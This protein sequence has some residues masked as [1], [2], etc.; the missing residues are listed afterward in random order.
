[1]VSPNRSAN[2]RRVV[3][4]DS[5]FFSIRHGDDGSE[6]NE[7]RDKDGKEDSCRDGNHEI[8]ENLNGNES[9]DK[10]ETQGRS[11]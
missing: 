3:Y 2:R 10:R 8:N 9:K 1:M 7:A 5:N 4:A 11:S 6:M